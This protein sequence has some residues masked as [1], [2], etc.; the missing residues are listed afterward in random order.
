MDVQDDFIVGIFNYCDRWC[1]RCPFTGR[2][3]LF[4]DE[5][6]MEFEHDH[7]P[8]SEPMR[9]RIA[10]SLGAVAA[11]LDLTMADIEQ[12]ATHFQ[13]PEIAPEHREVEERAR[14]H[15]HAAYRRFE[16]L[17]RP[18]DPA[19]ADAREVILHYSFLLAAKV[20]RALIGI[21]RDETSDVQSDAN[22]SAKVVLTV[23]E[24][25][26][27]AWTTM[28]AG[29]LGSAAEPFLADLAWLAAQIDRLFPRA[30]HFVRPGFDE[31]AEVA[32]LEAGDW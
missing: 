10:R 29:P 9:D 13:L 27:A 21:S 28:G 12:T 20:H 14:D 25:L 18:D 2:C 3:R 8:L 17:P 7:G 31:P 4:A 19:A 26:Q 1:E 24:R 16:K 32:R 23:I 11:E 30:S 15:G 5:S 22:G 6:E